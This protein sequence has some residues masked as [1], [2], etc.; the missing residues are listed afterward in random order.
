LTVFPFWRTASQTVAEDSLFPLFTLPFYFC[1]RVV[2]LFS[3]ENLKLDFFFLSFF[4]HKQ[5]SERV[6]THK[7]IIALLGWC[8][9]WFQI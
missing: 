9:F 4:F 7:V 8:I 5:N 6:L 3:L 2:T 1:Y